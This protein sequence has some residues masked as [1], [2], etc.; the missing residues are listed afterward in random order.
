MEWHPKSESGESTIS[1]IS[2]WVGQAISRKI[3]VFLCN[4]AN[5]QSVTNGLATQLKNL[6]RN[7][8]HSNDDADIDFIKLAVQ[9]SLK[10][11]VTVIG[12]D[13]DL[14]VL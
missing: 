3:A 12:E 5:I 14:L 7:V 1:N 11:L 9:T 4:T 8:F 10:C 2:V 6:A 13:T